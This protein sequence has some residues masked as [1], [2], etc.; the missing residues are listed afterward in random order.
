MCNTSYSWYYNSYNSFH[1]STPPT[2]IPRPS[3]RHN[4]TPPYILLT[5]SV[6]VCTQTDHGLACIVCCAQCSLYNNRECS[7]TR[8][9]WHMLSW[10]RKSKKINCISRVKVTTVTQQ[11]LSFY[12]IIITRL[13]IW[14][15]KVSMWYTTHSIRILVFY[16]IMYVYRHLPSCLCLYT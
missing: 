1:C 14:F 9:N 10:T 15:G 16:V 7:P 2:F 8:G 5:H 13:E 3:K 6:H 12:I 4:I 11:S